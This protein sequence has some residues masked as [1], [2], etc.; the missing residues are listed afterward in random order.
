MAEKE[1]EKIEKSGGGE[2]VP[3]GEVGPRFDDLFSRRAEAKATFKD[4]ILELVLPKV[5]PAKRTTIKVERGA[6]HARAG[7][8]RHPPARVAPCFG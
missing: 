8:S 3:F 4:G 6:L 7:G 2:M 1:S 5:E